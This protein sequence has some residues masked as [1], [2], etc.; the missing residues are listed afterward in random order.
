MIEGSCPSTNPLYPVGDQVNYFSTSHLSNIDFTTNGKSYCPNLGPLIRLK[1]NQAA[2]SIS[3]S[4]T[5]HITTMDLSRWA[6]AR[7]S[8]PS[9]ST[10]YGTTLCPSLSMTL[11]SSAHNFLTSLHGP[12]SSS[13]HWRI[14]RLSKRQKMSLLVPFNWKLILPSL[15]A[16][17]RSYVLTTFP[18][19][20]CT[21]SLIIHSDRYVHKDVYSSLHH[22]M[23][24]TPICWYKIKARITAKGKQSLCKPSRGAVMRVIKISN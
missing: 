21:D 16:L 6:K 2:L 24:L 14:S 10:V 22:H 15:R 7:I 5:P 9:F 8:T 20:D 19:I 18:W 13:L 4:K 17:A 3:Y 23:I 1:F 12:E 11:V